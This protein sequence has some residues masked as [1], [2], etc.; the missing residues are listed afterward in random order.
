MYDP[1]AIGTAIIGLD[2]VRTSQDAE[3]RPRRR[4]KRAVTR[5][6][7]P[8]VR[9]LASGALRALVARVGRSAPAQP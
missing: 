6:H 4:G 1:A 5:P 7:L 9:H 3:T 2:A 8:P